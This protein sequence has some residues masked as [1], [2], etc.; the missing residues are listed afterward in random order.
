M[1]WGRTNRGDRR[2]VLAEGYDPL[3][4]WYDSG[5]AL[6]GIRLASRFVDP[7]NLK[8]WVVCSR[9]ETLLSALE[10]V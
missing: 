6:C 5:I 9:C 7:N 1:E 4:D 8:Y 3:D 10:S 2:H